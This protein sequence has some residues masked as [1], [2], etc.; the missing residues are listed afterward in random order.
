MIAELEMDVRHET[1]PQ[2]EFGR[3]LKGLRAVCRGCFFSPLGL[4]TGLS[5]PRWGGRRFTP[6]N[7]V[8]LKKKKKK[9]GENNAGVKSHSVRRQQPPMEA[10]QRRAKNKSWIR[11]ETQ[12]NV[13]QH[14]TQWLAR[15]K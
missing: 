6:V 10:F 14:A 7:L 1:K 15:E 12:E 9:P 5:S 8:W 11:V 3:S 2:E 4:S 13:S